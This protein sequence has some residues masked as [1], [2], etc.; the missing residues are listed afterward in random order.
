MSHGRV[1]LILQARMGSTRLPGKSMM[2]L[3]GAPLLARIFERVKR[4]TR[5]DEIVLATTDKA[6]DDVLKDLAV[7]YSIPCFRGSENDLLDRYYRAAL[8]HKAELVLRL[9][10][11]NPVPEPEEIDRI[12]AY[13]QSTDNAYSSNL[14]QVLGNGYPDGI[15]AEAISL[16]ALE[17]AWKDCTGAYEREH[18]HLNFYDYQTAKPTNPE[19]F[20]VGTVQCPPAFRRPDLV[21]DVNTLEEYEFIRSL[22]EHLYPRNPRFHITDIIKWYDEVY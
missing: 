5:C 8:E 6:R 21:L 4:C 12:V 10:A 2:D 9:P 1:V 18:L 14:A 7:E 16:W 17:K 19:V 13:H 22:Y 15:G 3:H 20:K 11:D